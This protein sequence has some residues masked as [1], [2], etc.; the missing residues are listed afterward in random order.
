LLILTASVPVIKLELNFT[1]LTEDLKVAPVKIGKIKTIK[2]DL[3]LI[4]QENNG[5]Q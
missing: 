5:V 3:V 1:G 4:D 2:I